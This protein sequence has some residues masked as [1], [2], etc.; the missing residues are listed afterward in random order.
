MLVL[1]QFSQ[2][3]GGKIFVAV[4]FWPTQW[5]EQ[6]R[7]DQQRDMVG[8]KSKIIRRLRAVQS[9]WQCRQAQQTFTFT[10]HGTILANPGAATV[11]HTHSRRNFSVD[12]GIPSLGI[13]TA[14]ARSEQG[15][16][17]DTFRLETNCGRLIYDHVAAEIQ[18]DIPPLQQEMIPPSLGLSGF[19]AG[20]RKPDRPI[21]SNRT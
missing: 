16:I 4:R 19:S 7:L 3:H 10:I 11:Y 2:L 9:R 14:I 21:T 12:T 8:F 18:N 15:T 1:P 13:I 5:F 17:V 6:T 20:T